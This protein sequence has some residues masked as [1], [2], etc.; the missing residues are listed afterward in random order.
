MKTQKQRLTRR[1]MMQLMTVFGLSGPAALE[2]S[3]QARKTISP[4]IVKTAMTLIGQDFDDERINIITT[5]LQRRLDE[6]QL[7]RDLELD[8]MIGPATIFMAKGW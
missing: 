5:A 7:L 8:D 6:M 4:E 3:A 2:L 1:Q